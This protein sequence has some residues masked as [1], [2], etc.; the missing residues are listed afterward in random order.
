[1]TQ[2]LTWHRKTFTRVTAGI[3]ITFILTLAPFL[4]LK[5]APSGTDWGKLSEIS[6]IYATFLS[7]VAVLG[8]A[9]ALAYQARQ[10]TLAHAEAARVFHRELTLISLNDPTLMACWA[11][12]FTTLSLQEAR[13]VMFVNLIVSEWFSQYRLHQYTDDA[14]LVLFLR[15]FRG[16]VAR[17]H[18]E[19]SR[20]PRRNMYEAQ[21]NSRG[22]QF[23]SIVDKAFAQ[24]TAE[25]PATPASAYFAADQ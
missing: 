12:T 24:A 22:M 25:G 6:Q 15:H 19:L 1:M 8:V 5:I 21:G 7:T 17:K 9:A 10:T 23:V 20:G 2:R 3:A 18:W 14:L 13:Q 11:P 4:I 16:E